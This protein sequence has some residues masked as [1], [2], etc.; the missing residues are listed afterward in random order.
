MKKNTHFPL[1]RYIAQ[2]LG[3]FRKSLAFCSIALLGQNAVHAQPCTT[4]VIDSVSSVAASCPGSGQVYISAQGSVNMQYTV[5]SGATIIQGPISPGSFNSLQAGTYKLRAF[6]PEGSGCFT[7]TTVV[8][9][10]AYLPFSF[11]VTVT[12]VC[13]G[14]TAGTINVTTNPGS[15]TPLQVAYWQGDANTPDA[16]LTYGSSLTYTVPEANFGTWNVRVKDA[17]GVAS[18]TQV[19]VANPYPS[20]LQIEAVRAWVSSSGVQCVST[21]PNI[22]AYVRL[23][24]NGVWVSYN[25]LPAAGVNIEVYEDVNENCIADPSEH[26]PS[27]NHVIMPG[28]D[29]DISIPRNKKLV[30]RMITP[31]GQ[32][33]N[34]CYNG[35]TDQSASISSSILQEGCITTANPNGSVIIQMYANDYATLPYAYYIESTDPAY[36]TSGTSTGTTRWLNVNDLAYGETYTVTMVDACGDTTINVLTPPGIAEPISAAVVNVHLNDCVN[37]NNKTSARVRIEGYFPGLSR[38]G[39]TAII[40]N[41]TDIGLVGVRNSARSFWFNGVTPGAVNTITITSPDCSSSINVNFTVP[42]AATVLNQ[43]ITASMGQLCSATGSGILTVNSTYNGT[44]LPSVRIY[45]VGTSTP[46]APTSSGGTITV[47]NLEVGKYYAKL[48]IAWG[49]NFSCTNYALTSDT[50]EVYPSGTVP[51]ITR[52]VTMVCDAPLSNPNE[53]KASIEFIGAAPFLVEYKPVSSTTWIV[54]NTASMGAEL[55]EGLT[56]GTTYDI[57]ITDVCGSIRTDLVTVA[58]LGAV[59]MSN[60]NQ[61]CLNSSYTLSAPSFVGAS[62]SWKKDGVITGDNTREINFPVFS[63]ANTGNYE[64]TISIGNCIVRTVNVSLYSQFCDSTITPVSLAGN[65][66]NDGNGMTDNMVNGIGTN[67]GGAIFVVLTDVAGKVLATREV[68]ATG[69]YSFDNLP[70]NTYKVLVSA[71]RPAAGTTM[72][73]SQLPTNW[74]STGE[75]HGL[76]TA[77]GRDAIIDGI[78]TISLTTANVSNVNFGIERRP[79]SYNKTLNVTG[80]PIVGVPV[81]LTT[82]LAGSDM[83]DNNGVEE[84]WDFNPIVITSLPSNGFTLTY[85]GVTLGVNDTIEDYNPALLTVTPTT[86]T[87]A[88]TTTTVFNYATIDSAKVIDATPATYTVVFSSPLPIKLASFTAAAKGKIAVLNWSTIT[89]QNNRGFEIERNAGNNDWMNIGFV[90]TK[91]TNGNSTEKISYNFNDNTPLKGL[92]YYRLK[93]IDNDSKATFSEERIVRFGNGNVIAIYPNP[94][95]NKIIIDG[96]EGNEQVRIY[97]IAGRMVYNS[98]TKGT[99]ETIDLSELNEGAYQVTVTQTNGDVATH[100]IVKLK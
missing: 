52:K 35:I 39:T 70:P 15:S 68:S 2:R 81:V 84:T 37:Q 89:E 75:N 64:C 13:A 14:N 71:T 59:V 66:W 90:G 47:P 29:D 34:Y 91:A 79:E 100:K 31:C 74:V 56:I 18:T 6:N 69:A 85:N 94:A 11:N 88:G 82:P 21:Q 55:L 12:N 45:K 96:L 40:T 93:Q 5:L 7:D 76:P 8:V 73:T 10:N 46:I 36:N 58:A 32:V 20:G 78:Q 86:A 72:T 48:D 63:N 22:N 42:S 87:P 43:T 28:T 65:I 30:I 38:P 97:D 92:N 95:T 99:R 49:S 19:V 3:F 98:A 26:L 60:T 51:T 57:R 61:P 77:T 44:G 24:A 50:L 67:A 16:T 23:V 33:S 83:E 54:K 80:S 41:G 25:S 9:T 1:Q 4:P 17:C 53:G 62:Y 27:L